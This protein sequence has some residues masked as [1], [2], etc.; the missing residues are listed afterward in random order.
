MKHHVQKSALQLVYSVT[1]LFAEEDVQK[2][3]STTTLT[4][5]IMLQNMNCMALRKVIPSTTPRA[6]EQSL[7][8]LD[9][10]MSKNPVAN[11]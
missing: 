4:S 5:S 6:C 8:Q 1:R 7:K 9:A 2:I 10:G 3:F 11:M